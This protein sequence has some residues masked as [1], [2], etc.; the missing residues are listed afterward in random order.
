MWLVCLAGSFAFLIATH[1][2]L[3]RALPNWGALL[4]LI[5][6]LP[7]SVALLWWATRSLGYSILAYGALFWLLFFSALY[8]FAFTLSQSS[9]SVKLIGMLRDGALDRSEIERSYSPGYMVE[10]RIE[11]LFASGLATRGPDGLKLTPRGRLLVKSYRLARRLL[12]G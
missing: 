11:R 10:R 6:A 2:L 12:H 3:G 1:H 4:R 5:V 8:V 9:I 7:P